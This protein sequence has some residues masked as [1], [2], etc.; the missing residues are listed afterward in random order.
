[1]TAATK[2]I[3]WANGNY[4]LLFHYVYSDSELNPPMEEPDG[5]LTP[6]RNNAAGKMSGFEVILNTLFHEYFPDDNRDK[7]Y[8]VRTTFRVV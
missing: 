5:T 6:L 4:S 7:G 1:M 8:N 3:I 2:Y